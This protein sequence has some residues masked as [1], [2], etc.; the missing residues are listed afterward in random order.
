LIE[1]AEQK[2]DFEREG[3]SQTDLVGTKAKQGL[4]LSGR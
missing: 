4:Y 2:A 1:A 3:L